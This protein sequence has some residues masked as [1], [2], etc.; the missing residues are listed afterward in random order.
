MSRQHGPTRAIGEFCYNR[1]I[2]FG[3]A[4]ASWFKNSSLE[5]SWVPRERWAERKTSDTIFVLGSG[6]SISD[7]S[8]EQWSHIGSHD[9]FGINLSFLTMRN[10]TY[11]L[12]SYERHATPSLRA[13]FVPE[14]REAC[15][16]ALWFLPSKCLF[17]LA[18]PRVIPEL[19]PPRPQIAVFDLPP[20]I[21]LGG[22]RPFRA[23]DFKNTLSYRGTIGVALELVR[24]MKYRKIVLIGVDLHTY[25]HFFEDFKPL[26]PWRKSYK[27]KKGS[28]GRFE[29]MVIRPGK[30]RT[31]EEYFHALHELYCRHNGVELFVA[32]PKSILT[33]RIPVYPGF[34]S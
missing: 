4:A 29:S 33:P 18:H 15:R 3:E 34:L 28:D 1:V 14:A 13:A 12:L 27:E 20:V 5:Y 9:S 7:L 30:E 32:D 24:Q 23:D 26:A 31:G 6:P 25:E 16:E 22:D 11:H 2:P 21:R 10:P 8:E 19:F 17:R